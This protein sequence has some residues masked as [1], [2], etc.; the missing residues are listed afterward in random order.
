MMTLYI[1]LL[2]II[3]TFRT[4]NSPPP[5]PAI[6]SE[7]QMH[8][9]VLHIFSTSRIKLGNEEEEISEAKVNTCALRWRL[10][11]PNIRLRGQI[12]VKA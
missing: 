3:I 5:L 4:I 12:T 11:F 6:E 9:F 8:A 10:I 7:K 2:V 1:K